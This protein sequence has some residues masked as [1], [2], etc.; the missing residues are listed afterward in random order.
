MVARRPADL[1]LSLP[2]GGLACPPAVGTVP[3]GPRR[4]PGSNGP[5][6]G[7]CSRYI[8]G[9]PEGSVSN[10]ATVRITRLPVGQLALFERP[11]DEVWTSASPAKA[12]AAG[13]VIPADGREPTGGVVGRNTAELSTR[14]RRSQGG[15]T[16]HTHRP[17]PAPAY[18]PL[19]AALAQLVRDRW[20]AEQTDHAKPVALGLVPSIMATM[21][22]HRLTAEETPA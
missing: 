13:S 15:L 12:V 8:S 22:Q 18:D 10:H 19:V 20:A 4:H 2:R 16:E 17:T 6:Y 11:S 21:A 1:L 7:H 14:G 9:G 5:V 3:V